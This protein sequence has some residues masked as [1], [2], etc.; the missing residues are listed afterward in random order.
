MFTKRS[1][2]TLLTTV[3]EGLKTKSISTAVSC[4][5]CDHIWAE[6]KGKRLDTK[7]ETELEEGDDV[8]F[9]APMGNI[10]Y[11]VQNNKLVLTQW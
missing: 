10:R 8:V 2:A 4:A 7:P 1:F 11:T 9:W 5:Q 6:R 3:T